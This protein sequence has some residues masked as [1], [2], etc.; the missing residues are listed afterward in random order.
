MVQELTSA[1]VK[2]KAAELGFDLCGIARAER[3]PHLA[4][5]AEWI[6]RGFSGDMAYL[7]DSLQERQD[8][9]KVLP[10][11]ESVVCVALVYNTDQPYSNTLPTGGVRRFR[12]TR[13]ET[14]TTRSCDRGCVHSCAGWPRPPAQGSRRSRAWTPARCRNASLPS[15]RAWAGSART[16]V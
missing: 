11:V 5:L 14:T 15:R 2:A 6:D 7:A 1:G 8:P 9:A 16:P 3:Y 13:G 12:A 10:S 4:R